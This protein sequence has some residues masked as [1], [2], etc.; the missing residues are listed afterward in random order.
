[1]TRHL[2][3]LRWTALGLA[4]VALQAQLTPDAPLK[5]FRLPM[6]GESSY[7]TWEIRGD[8]G[9]YLSETQGEIKGLEMLIYSGRADLQVLGRIQTPLAIVD[10]KD[11]SAQGDSPLHM[12]GPGFTVDGEDWTWDGAERLLQ[13]KEKARV[14][15]ADN[16]ILLE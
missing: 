11:R 16:L 7:K 13:I 15:I 9:R 1:M 2:R 4:G 5:N 8:E 3:T 14:E 10:L 12:E 6:F